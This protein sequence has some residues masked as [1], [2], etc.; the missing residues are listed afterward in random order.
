MGRQELRLGPAVRRE[1]PFLL[2]EEALSQ[3]H[4]CSQM[5]EFRHHHHLGNA[6]A[7]KLPSES[8]C[9]LVV[10]SECLRALEQTASG[11]GWVACQGGLGQCLSALN[12][13]SECEC[14]C[15]CLCV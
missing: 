12:M 5:K 14:V 9:P 7:G 3:T 10:K 11:L 8:H 15:M 4:Q 1:G 2:P 6:K 13:Q